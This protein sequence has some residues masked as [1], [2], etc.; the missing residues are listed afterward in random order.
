MLNVWLQLNSIGVSILE[1]PSDLGDQ[2]ATEMHQQN[3]DRLVL[4][5]RTSNRGYSLG[6]C[7]GTTP[8]KLINIKGKKFK[9]ENK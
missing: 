6:L 5:Q 3:A 4:Y 2:S 9:K 1:G 7:Q 8:Q